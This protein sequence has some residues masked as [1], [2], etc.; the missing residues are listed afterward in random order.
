MVV[1]AKVSI[2]GTRPLLMHHFGEDAIPLER[3]ERTGV[4]G[5]DP[6]E[7]KRSVLALPDGHL[8]LDP[9]YIFGAIRNGARYTKKGR[10]SI[11]TAVAASLQVLDDIVLLDRSMPDGTLPRDP[12]APVYLDV[13]YVKN[14]V[15]K[16][17]NVRYRLACSAGWRTSFSLMWDSTIVQRSTMHLVAID[18]GRF[19]GLADGRAIGFGR[20]AVESFEVDGL[21]DAAPAAN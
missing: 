21:D 13:R 16:A 2:V 9:T 14:P 12:K 7:W 20:F 5:N 15:S 8:Y 11:A 6:E 4:A 17:G 19:V 1:T 10:G 18:A 3:G